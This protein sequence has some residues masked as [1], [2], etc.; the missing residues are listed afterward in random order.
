MYQAD[1]TPVLGDFAC[2]PWDVAASSAR[3]QAHA[4]G[5]LRARASAQADVASAVQWHRQFPIIGAP[6]ER[7]ELAEQRARRPALVGV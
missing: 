5:M 4:D 6:K 7:C 2:P 3:P 1:T